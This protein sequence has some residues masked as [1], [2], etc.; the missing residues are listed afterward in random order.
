[1]IT[2]TD[3]ALINLVIRT[4][5][6]A[7]LEPCGAGSL[8]WTEICVPRLHLEAAVKLLNSDD[9]FLANNMRWCVDH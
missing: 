4:L 5:E 6:A 2:Q 3:R 9:R 8:G 1:M 7:G